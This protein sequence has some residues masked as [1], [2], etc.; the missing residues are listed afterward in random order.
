MYVPII[1]G[2]DSSWS[3]YLLKLLF[4]LCIQVVDEKLTKRDIIRYGPYNWTYIDVERIC[5]G[6]CQY[7]LKEVNPIVHMMIRNLDDL[8]DSRVAMR[9]MAAVVMSVSINIVLTSGAF[10]T[11]SA[12]TFLNAGIG[13]II[14][15]YCKKERLRCRFMAVVG[16]DIYS[17]I[18]VPQDVTTIE[19]WAI[20][21]R[22]VNEI[23]SYFGFVVTSYC[24]RYICDFLQEISLFGRLGFRLHRV[25]IY[26]DERRDN[27]HLPMPKLLNV[28]RESMCE[29]QRRGKYEAV[30][31]LWLRFVLLTRGRILMSSN[32]MPEHRYFLQTS[33]HFGLLIM[34]FVW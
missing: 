31:C 9:S 1:S 18:N 24:F 7:T 5:N 21:D 3:S 13:N 33:S 34:P 30:P 17:S 23:Y 6:V 22:I 2:F 19:A 27:R 29:L 16:D 28:Y 25:G 26:S 11:S 12:N 32:D 8:L 20:V 10:T 14:S 4:L 15:F